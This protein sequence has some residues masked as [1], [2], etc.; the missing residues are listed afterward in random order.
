[1]RKLISVLVLSAV[2]SAAISSYAQQ[3]KPPVFELTGTVLSRSNTEFKVYQRVKVGLSSTHTFKITRDTVFYG[4]VMPGVF[5]IV[6]YTQRML[7]PGLFVRTAVE[8][9]GYQK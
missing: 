5:V 3:L 7:R 6:R 1:M 8:V 9:K 2:L 4:L